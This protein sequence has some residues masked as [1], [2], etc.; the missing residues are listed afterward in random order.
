MESH[1]VD[2]VLSFTALLFLVFGWSNSVVIILVGLIF[3]HSL[4]HVRHKCK[5]HEPNTK[6]KSY[7]KK[8]KK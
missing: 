3:I 2:S 7:L 8:K 4:A 5:C 6:L 1:V